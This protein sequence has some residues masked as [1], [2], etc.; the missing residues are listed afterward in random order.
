MKEIPTGSRYARA[1]FERAKAKNEIL[2]CRQ[3]LTAAGEA[4][5]RYPAVWQVLLHPFVPLKDKVDLA[6]TALGEFASPLVIHFLA[7]LIQRKRLAVL[8]LIVQEFATLADA[9][10]GLRTARVKSATALSS[11][12]QAR[13]VQQLEKLAGQKVQLDVTVDPGLLAGASVRIG[14]WVLDGSVRGQLNC[15]KEAWSLAV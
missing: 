11:E 10:A 3:G 5:R 14:D 4:F 9:A 2:A 12:E 13:M 7:L 6:R 8:P 15:L 1:F